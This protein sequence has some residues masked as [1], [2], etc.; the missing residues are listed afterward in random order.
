MI[1]RWWNFLQY[2]EYCR[3][4][5]LWYYHYCGPNIF[6]VSNRELPVSSHPYFRL[7]LACLYLSR[8]NVTPCTSFRGGYC[9]LTKHI[10]NLQPRLSILF[11]FPAVW[12]YG[13]GLWKPY[14]CG[15]WCKLVTSV[16][17]SVGFPVVAGGRTTSL[18]LF[19]LSFFMFINSVLSLILKKKKKSL[20]IKSKHLQ[21]FCGHQC[22]RF[23]W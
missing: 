21:G 13:Y 19:P 7:L 1:Y 12:M 5:V 15:G 2:I 14:T 17:I 10:L 11:T 16:V 20:I 23:S 18:I 9:P 22:S 6:T 3:Y 4:C 8:A